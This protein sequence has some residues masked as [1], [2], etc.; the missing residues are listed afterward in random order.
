MA[1][2][3]GLNITDGD[4]GHHFGRQ[5]AEID[6]GDARLRISSN[7]FSPHALREVSKSIQAEALRDREEATQRLEKNDYSDIKDGDTD[8]GKDSQ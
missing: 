5:I 1:P 8:G 7:C 6:V 4:L 2:R 3:S